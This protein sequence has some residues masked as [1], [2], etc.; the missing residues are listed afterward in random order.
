MERQAEGPLSFY[1]RFLRITFYTFRC[2][3]ARA[4]TRIRIC[5]QIHI[6]SAFSFLSVL[7]LV[8]VDLLSPILLHPPCRSPSASP[9][10]SALP[11]SSSSLLYV[12]VRTRICVYVRLVSIVV[13]EVS[14]R[15]ALRSR[16]ERAALYVGE[17]ENVF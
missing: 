1:Q 3:C 16:G 12:R 10:R 8:S 4:P 5:G 9:H 17:R 15:T 7:P 13:R 2:S 6:Y 11:S 14:C